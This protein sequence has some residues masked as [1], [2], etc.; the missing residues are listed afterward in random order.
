MRSTQYAEV[1][2][3]YINRLVS[4]KRVNGAL[5][6]YRREI[7]RNPNDPGLYERLAEFL[8]QNK[9][10]VEIEQVYAKATQ[11]FQ[12]R[13][14]HHKLARWYLRQKQT[15]AFDSLTKAVVATFSGTEL[16]SYFQQVVANANLDAAFYRQVNLYAYQRFPHDL[17]FVKN[18]L[19]AYQREAPATRA[20]TWR[21][22]GK[23]GTTTMNFDPGSLSGSPAKAS[24]MQ[25]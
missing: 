19:N 18:L 3:R 14:W 21:C 13:S 24:S 2:D 16:D 7:D 22:C 4:L 11:Q 12:D 10:A 9:M 20:P 8:N 23:T 5:A 6:L 1:L 17:V 15:A 25:K